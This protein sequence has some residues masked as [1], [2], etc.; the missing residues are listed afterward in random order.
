MSNMEEPEQNDMDSADDADYVLL[1]PKLETILEETVIDE[2][3]VQQQKSHQDNTPYEECVGPEDAALVNRFEMYTYFFCGQTSRMPVCTWV[4]RSNSPAEFK[5]YMYI[6]AKQYMKQAIEFSSPNEPVWSSKEVPT[7]EDLT[8]YIVFKDRT[9]KRKYVLEDAE[10]FMLQRWAH[11]NILVQLYVH[12][13]EI[14]SKFAYDTVKA[15]LFIKPANPTNVDREALN[16]QRLQSMVKRLEKIHFQR[17]VPKIDDAFKLWARLILQSPL[18][19]RHKLYYQQPPEPLLDNF[20]VLEKTRPKRAAVGPAQPKDCSDG[21]GFEEE[22]Q[23]LRRTV[24]QIK[25]LVE[26][27]DRRVELL[28]EKCHGFNRNILEGDVPPA[29]KPRWDDDDDDE[30]E[31]EGDM[32]NDEPI[33]DLPPG[34]ILSVD[35]VA[36]VAGQQRAS[37]DPLRDE[38]KQEDDSDW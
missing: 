25:D 4:I 36:S 28:E 11:K 5:D 8:N 3:T 35:S 30:V 33:I 22:V 23:V 15:K 12:S 17:L 14:N 9:S 24:T 34:D 20:V 6:L 27:L 1:E 18:R 26:M 29:K 7:Q 2:L 16:E 19:D 31:A 37:P 21:Y 10:E 38:I 13:K 32:Q